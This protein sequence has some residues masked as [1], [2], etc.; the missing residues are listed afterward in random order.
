MS[1]GAQQYRFGSWI[2]TF[3]DIPAFDLLLPTVHVEL[4]LKG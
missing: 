3:V 1:R 2:V 4:A